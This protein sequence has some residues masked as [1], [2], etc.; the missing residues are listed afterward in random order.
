MIDL[1]CSMTQK[2]IGLGM[3]K[4]QPLF[5]KH[6]NTNSFSME[7]STSERNGVMTTQEN[8]LD[9]DSRTWR[10]I[11]N[12]TCIRLMTHQKYTIC[13]EPCRINLGTELIA[14]PISESDCMHQSLQQEV[15]SIP[16]VH[17]LTPSLSCD[18][19]QWTISGASHMPWVQN[20]QIGHTQEVWEATMMA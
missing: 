14:Q 1:G 8:S 20:L 3:G 7:A 2:G 10:Y 16:Q 11:E 6:K 18:I 13:H 17:W 4:V 19:G 9:S 15:W 12:E 5:N